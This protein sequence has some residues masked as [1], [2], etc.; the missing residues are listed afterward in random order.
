MFTIISVGKLSAPWR[1]V[2]EQY[3]VRLGPYLPIKVIEI[4]EVSFGKNDDVEKIKKQEAGLL[5][6]YLKPDAHIIALHPDAKTPSTKKFAEQLEGWRRK[7][8]IIFMI[9]GPHGIHESILEKAS[10]LL[11]L[12]PL[13]FTHQM[14]RAILLEQLYR[15]IMREKGKYDY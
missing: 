2:A 8:E 3:I 15:C 5:I 6:K 9:G 11:S 4:A 1:D 10:E 12:S 13:T 7:R 14:T